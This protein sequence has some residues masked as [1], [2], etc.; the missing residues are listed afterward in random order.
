MRGGRKN[1]PN[2]NL[3]KY[4]AT[5]NKLLCPF[6]GW[7]SYALKLDIGS[8]CDFTLATLGFEVLCTV[9]ADAIIHALLRHGPVTE[10]QHWVTARVNVIPSLSHVQST[11]FASIPF[12]NTGPSTT[13]LCI[14]VYLLIIKSVSWSC[15]T[16]KGRSSVSWRHLPNCYSWFL[17]FCSH[18]RLIILTIFSSYSKA[19]LPFTSP[20]F[21][22]L[23]S[24]I[25]LPQLSPPRRKVTCD[26]DTFSPFILGVLWGPCID[27]AAALYPMMNYLFVPPPPAAAGSNFAWEI[28][29]DRACPLPSICPTLS[30]MEHSLDPTAQAEWIPLPITHPKTAL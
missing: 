23:N 3:P 9:T 20:A 17:S 8:D 4:N 10:L 2:S 12:F 19:L 15:V 25:V 1:L 21:L 11:L 13:T 6:H 28:F 7:F 30:P 5:R 22:C 24:R 27:S 18:P 29:E 26:P 14:E 16:E